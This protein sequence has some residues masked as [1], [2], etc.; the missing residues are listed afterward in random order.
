MK[1]TLIIFLIVYAAALTIRHVWLHSQLKKERLRADGI[2]WIYNQLAREREY[3][4]EL[5]LDWY[6]KYQNQLNANRSSIEE[7]D[8]LTDRMMSNSETN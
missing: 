3:S 1:T 4:A 6:N 8:L 2:E 7:N 5:C